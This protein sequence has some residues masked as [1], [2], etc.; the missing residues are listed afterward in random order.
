[1]RA[2]KLQINLLLHPASI[3]FALIKIFIA[4]LMYRS[5]IMA[6]CR[7][8]IGI[9]LL[10]LGG[11][12]A[13]L[14]AI[15][16]DEARGHIARQDY[17]QAVPAFRTLMRNRSM[18]SRADCNKWFGEALCMTGQYEE[19][20]PYLE[21][22][23]KRQVKGAYWYLGI[24]RQKQYDF[25]GAIAALEK[26][27][28]LMRNS[29]RWKRCSDSIIAECEIGQR[30]LSRVQDVTIIDSLVVPKRAFFLHYRLGAESGR[31]LQ[32]T[33]H[34]G[35]EHAADSLLFESQTG[36]YRLMVLRNGLST[37]LYES[38]CFNDRWEAPS[39]IASIKTNSRLA[40]PFLRSDGETL[41]FASAET[42]GMGGLDIYKTHYNVEDGVYYTPER[43]GMPFNSPGDDYMLAV[44]ETHQVGWWA[45]E[46]RGQSDFVTI[47]LFLLA[48]DI[49]YLEGEQLSRARIDRI[50]DTWKREGGY[51]DLV[52]E[53]LSAPQEQKEM[54]RLNIVIDDRRVY[55]SVEEFKNP[56]ARAFYERTTAL[57][58][59]HEALIAELE[60][61][62]KEWRDAGA[63]RKRQLRSAILQREKRELQMQI[64]IA[65]QEK[66][67][68][69][70]EISYRR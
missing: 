36:D 23:A 5:C 33:E 46:R 51:R 7:K 2:G 56:Q 50:A 61:F 25:S 31:L 53:I 24:C 11:W 26:Y 3:I 10:V 43:L 29:E 32:A 19:A 17:G 66:K 54:V 69:N 59:E 60:A 9:L 68:R 42:P 47:Y 1:V 6:T 40:Y 63:S 30:A 44:D 70:L 20:I 37:R 45:T 58:G 57:Q 65:E 14:S 13:P 52:N 18:A 34:G 8:S 28:S 15:T 12:F 67:Y 55:S 49:S 38:H 21:Y 4:E 22:A 27:K 64:Q 41:Y 16:L 62:R 39:L 48:D 35:F